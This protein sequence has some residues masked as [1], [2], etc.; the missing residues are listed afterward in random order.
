MGFRSVAAA[1]AMFATAAMLII[2]S[3]L[4]SERSK[5]WRFYVAGMTREADRILAACDQQ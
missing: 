4:A 5:T 2:V 1:G 3:V